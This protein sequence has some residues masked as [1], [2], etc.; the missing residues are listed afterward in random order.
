M[1]MSRV[2]RVVAL[3]M[4]VAGCSAF[5]APTPAPLPTDVPLFPALMPASSDVPGIEGWA[6]APSE[7]APAP[8]PVEGPDTP[9][10]AAINGVEGVLVSFCWKLGCADGVP[11]APDTLPT[12]SPPLDLEI[13]DGASV[14][15]VTAWNGLQINPRSL[16]VPFEGTSIGDVPEGTAMLSVFVTF[17]QGGDAVYYWHF[18]DPGATGSLT[19]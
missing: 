4:I 16:E 15:G 13:P 9:P 8:P 17:D 2:V 7:V 10:L 1:R 14:A 12:I 18:V 3:T 6:P 11:G 19:P 5:Q